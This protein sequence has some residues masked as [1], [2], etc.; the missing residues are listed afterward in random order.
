MLKF[1]EQLLKHKLDRL[2]PPSRVAFA[3]SCA[4]RLASVFDRFA[5][6][7]ALTGRASLFDAALNYVWTHITTASKNATTGKI[8]AD[9]VALI[10]DQDAPG[11][12]PLTAY[13]SDALSALA[14]SLRCLQ[15]GDAQESAWAA[16]CTYEALDYFVT[17]RDDVSPSE[18]GV[19]LR[20]LNDP[21]IQAELEKQTRD[22]ADL[23]SAGDFLSPELLDRLR[24]RSAAQQAIT[25]TS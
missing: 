11:W 13:G 7:S 9:V 24:Q 14:Y 23:S 19:E 20:V 5:A 17:N 3:A 16:R 22:I 6:T 4:Q 12:T 21:V 18:P 2:P 25:I 1:E 10:P 15:S 8:L